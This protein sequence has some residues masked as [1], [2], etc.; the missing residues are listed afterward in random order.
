MG[1][2]GRREGAGR[3]RGAKDNRPRFTA[4]AKAKTAKLTRRAV[5]RMSGTQPLVY[6]LKIMNDPKQPQARRDKM[7]VAAA[8]FCHPRLT[9]IA[10][11]KRP[12][13]MSDAELNEAIAQAKE[14]LLRHGVGRGQWPRPV[15]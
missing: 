13:E 3:P 9:V 4:A 11:P 7:A 14:D 10:K 12:S 2:G 8:P 15:H 5:A 1:H 6:M